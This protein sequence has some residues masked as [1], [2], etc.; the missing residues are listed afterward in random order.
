MIPPMFP[1]PD[2]CQSG[3]VSRLQCIADLPICH[4]VPT[5][6]RWWP[7]RFMLNQHTITG[8][9]EYA[10]MAVRNKAPYCS[11]RLS[12][13]DMRMARP[14]MEMQMGM[15]VNKKRWRAASL[16]IA[17]TMENTKAAAQG[18]TVCS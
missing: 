12:C 5:A 2:S 9:A 1:N 17:T 8:M 6:L 14:E 10:P 3:S 7:P 4:A 11:G 13:T 15:M 18:G 16:A